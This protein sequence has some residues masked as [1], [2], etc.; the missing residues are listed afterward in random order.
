MIVFELVDIGGVGGAII[1]GIFYGDVEALV[2]VGGLEVIL[3]VDPCFSV[4]YFSFQHSNMDPKRS[5]LC[6]RL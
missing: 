2:S 6:I 1:S 3:Q 4:L 5:V